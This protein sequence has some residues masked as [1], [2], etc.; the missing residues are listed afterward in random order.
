[1]KSLT[2]TVYYINGGQYLLNDFE[3]NVPL[4]NLLLLAR[5]RRLLNVCTFTFTH[6]ISILFSNLPTNSHS[7]SAVNKNSS[8]T[9]VK[10]N[11]DVDLNV[12]ETT[13]PAFG[14]QNIQ[15]TNI[16]L[17]SHLSSPQ[18]PG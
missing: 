17:P 12:Q 10:I 2:L 16:P 11:E 3:L 9:L 8:V 15:G 18:T 7:M 1:M 14:F 13:A 4:T 5:G 6:L